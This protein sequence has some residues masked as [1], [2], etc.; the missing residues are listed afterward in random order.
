MGAVLPRPQSE[1]R[2]EGAAREESESQM[3]TVWWAMRSFLHFLRYGNLDRWDEPRPE[4]KKE[5]E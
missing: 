5:G 1:T 4:K 3:K 2:G